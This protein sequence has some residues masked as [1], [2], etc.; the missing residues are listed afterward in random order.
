MLMHWNEADKK[1]L[2]TVNSS[3]GCGKQDK[4]LV[5]MDTEA[6]TSQENP[7]NPWTFMLFFYPTPMDLLQLEK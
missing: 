1:W 7:Y 2:F 6:I 4:E 5:F 3:S